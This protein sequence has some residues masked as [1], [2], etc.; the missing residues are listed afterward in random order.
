M[1]KK[2]Q[3]VELTTS[4]EASIHCPF[5]GQMAWDTSD[6]SLT[7]CVHTLFVAHDEGFEFRSPRFNKAAGLA[8]KGNDNLS[9]DDRGTDEITDDVAIPDAVKFAAYAGPPSRFGAYIGFAPVED[10]EA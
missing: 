3:R 1:K 10:T 4:Y 6:G 8:E 7:P 2:I 5:C 9:A